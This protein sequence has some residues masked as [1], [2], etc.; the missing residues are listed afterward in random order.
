MIS[1]F[2]QP[3]SSLLHEM[4]SQS[5]GGGELVEIELKNR[6]DVILLLSRT[7]TSRINNG[8]ALPDGQ[9]ALLAACWS[10][11]TAFGFEPVLFIITSALLGIAESFV[12]LLSD[13]KQPK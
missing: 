6:S 2:S 5:T 3:C 11:T 12:T 9:S 7:W 1:T 13:R 10:R 4:F 8:A